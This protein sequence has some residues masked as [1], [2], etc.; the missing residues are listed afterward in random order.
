VDDMEQALGGINSDAFVACYPTCSDCGQ[1][2]DER[3]GCDEKTAWEQE[4]GYTEFAVIN[5]DGDEALAERMEAWLDENAPEFLTFTVRLC[6]SGEADS[7]YGVN[8]DGSLQVLGYS[9]PVPGEV[10]DL[11]NRAFVAACEAK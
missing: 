3:D 9:I 2:H 5:D 10:S 4:H 6:R 8:A 1:R 11:V 7:T